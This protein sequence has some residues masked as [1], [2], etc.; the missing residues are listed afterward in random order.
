MHVVVCLFVIFCL[1]TTCTTSIILD[2]YI[3][4]GAIQIVSPTNEGFSI[5]NGTSILGGERDMILIGTTQSQ[6]ATFTTSCGS[7]VFTSSSSSSSNGN[8]KSMLQY[9]GYDYSPHL[10]PNGLGGIDITNNGEYYLV[11]FS[12]YVEQEVKL[13]I[14]IYSGSN[15][16]YC[17]ASIELNPGQ[18]FYTFYYNSFVRVNSGCNFN[19]VGAIEIAVY[20]DVNVNVKIGY[21]AF[22]GEQI[23]TTRT[24]TPTATPTLSVGGTASSTQ[25]PSKTSIY[26]NTPSSS[27]SHTRTTT[28]TATISVGATPSQT[29]TPSRTASTFF[30]ESESQTRTQSSTHTPTPSSTHAYST[31]PKG[32]KITNIDSFYT[33]SSLSLEIPY[34]PHF[35]IQE[36]SFTNGTGIIGNERDLELMSWS[37]DQDDRFSVSIGD[38]FLAAKFPKNSYTG[39]GNVLLQYDGNDTSM[40]LNPNGLTFNATAGNA[41]CF[42]FEFY[43]DGIVDIS[44]TVYTGNAYCKKSIST[45][46]GTNSV[47]LFY[48][49]NFR[50]EGCDFTDIGAIE[51]EITDIGDATYATL[52]DFYTYDD[53]SFPA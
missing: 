22:D 17:F 44:L 26:G 51:F 15:T 46:A 10:N 36:T 52:N 8:G 41:N 28:P 30:Y 32:K 53:Y 40:M 43:C 20:F 33:P 11:S 3:V 21:I 48:F 14:N 5:E 37:G 13:D 29:R 19:N 24:P 18:T 38:Y 49:S 2:Y 47:Y 50:N 23:S 9:D 25:T 4:Y 6:G 31:G 42:Y 16:S 7:S 27:P 12:A 39:L 1:V 45:I 35:P 34:D